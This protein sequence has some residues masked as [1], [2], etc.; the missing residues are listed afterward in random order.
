MEAGGLVT[1]AGFDATAKEGDR[2]E[3]NERALPPK[4]TTDAVKQWLVDNLPPEK[5]RWLK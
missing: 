5:R 2:A 1:K 3:G 4:A